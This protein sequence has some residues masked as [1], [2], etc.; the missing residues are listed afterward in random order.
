MTTFIVS[1]VLLVA[2]YLF[3][4]KLTDRFF[5]SSPSRKTPAVTHEDGIDYK[6]LPTWKIFVIQ[7]LNIAGLG[8]IFGAI[9]GAAYGPMAYLWIVVGCI[10]MGAVHDYFSGMMSIRNGGRNMPDLVGKYL[11]REAKWVMTVLV[12]FLLL[13]VGVS[14]VTGP[15]DLIASMTGISKNIWLYVIF[16]YY[17]LATILPI[18]KIIG[19]IYPFMGAALLFMAVGVGAAMV[20]GDIRGTLDMQELTADSFRNFHSDPQNNILIPMLFIVISCG[21]IS[22]FHSTQSPLMA[23]CLDNEKHARPVFYGAMIAEGIVAMIWAT[24]AMTFFGGPEGLNRAAD[25]GIMIDGVLTKVTPA[26]AVN[27]ICNSWLGKVGAIIAVIGVI[28]CPITSGDTAFRSLRLTIADLVRSDQKPIIRRIV[29]SVPIFIVA[30]MCCMLDF[31]TIWK[32]VGIGNQA[33]ATFILWTASAYLIR[34]GKAHWITSVPA[35]F[36][37][38]VVVSYF[39]MAPHINGGLHL[40]P[41]AGY[42]TGAAVAVALFIF[43]IVRGRKKADT[44]IA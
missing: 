31:S 39:M 20:V 36:L 44:I 28:V 38:F 14:F 10:F 30:Y 34:E 32:Y 12:S 18:D 13:A 9:M 35:T 25:E 6:V 2:G 17:I 8:P 24:A 1:V 15:A 23:R 4:G 42:I 26:I 11:G 7:F 40:S 19:S 37:T 33:L 3:Y 29:I 5:G 16:A 22:G 43:C 41:A 21:A 27:M